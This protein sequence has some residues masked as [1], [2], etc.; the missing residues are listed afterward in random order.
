MTALAIFVKTPGLT[1]VKTRL[2]RD[3]GA[4]A[5]TEFH[6]RAAR[7][8]AAVARAA[9]P[10][11]QPYWAVAEQ[12]G[13]RD[14]LWAGFPSV[15]QGEGE[16]GSRLH[17]VYSR[18]LQRHGSVLLI[19]AD[20]P[21]VTPGLLSGAGRTLHQDAPFTIGPARDG[22]FWLFGGRLPVPERVWRG[23]A[24]STEETGAQL[25][26]ALRPSAVRTCPVLSDADRLDDLPGVLAALSELADP[27][28]E[29]TNLALWL[30]QLIRAPATQHPSGNWP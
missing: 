17:E 6:V 16:L 24:Y 3:I 22:G 10:D 29:Q 30:S 21:Q 7:C 5:A 28:P 20:A 11:V 13:V 8:V 9:M 27:L 18:L 23:I 4:T 15:W 2:A 25:L 19:G 26:A 12:P 14:P 1:P